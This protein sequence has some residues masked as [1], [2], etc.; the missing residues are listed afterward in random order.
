MSYRTKLLLLF[1]VTV[2]VT[3]TIVAWTASITMR[4]AFERVNNE[5]TAALVT[6]FQR[7][8]TRRGVEVTSQVEGIAHAK[9]TLRIA[10]EVARPNPDYAALVNEAGS[11]A[12][13]YQLEFLELL[14]DD[15]A[16]VSSA[17][18]PARFGYKESWITTTTGWLTQGAFLRQEDLPN[19]SALALM[20]V[21][22]VIVGEKR[23]YV[24]GGKK[25]GSEFLASLTLPEGMRALLYR[26][27]S[28][29]NAQGTLTDGAGTAISEERLLPLIT[30]VRQRPAEQAQNIAWTK[31]AASAEAFHALPLLGPHQEVLGMFLVG[32]SLAEEVLLARR[33]RSLAL[34]A[35]GM[36]IL[37]GMI[38]STWA[39]A[40]VTKP[41]EQLAGAAN[42]VSAG[43]WNTHV[44]VASRD[45]VGRLADAFNRMTEQLTEQRE[46][47]VQA[48]RVAAW[49]E[50]ARRLAHEL[51]N[52]LF[53][54]QITVENLLRAREMSEDQ[55]EEVFRESTGTLLAELAKLRAIISRFSDFAKMPAPQLQPVNLNE[56][57][58]A[59]IRVFEAQFTAPGKPAITKQLDL[60]KRL[61][62]IQADPELLQRAVQNLI[63]N[64]I[65][66]MPS[67]GTLR[68][69]TASLPSGVQ[70][71]VSDTG[72]G[73]TREECERLF[74]PYYTTKQH[75]TGLGLAIVQSVVSDHQGKISVESEP[76]KGTTFR[77]ILPFRATSAEPGN[78]V[79]EPASEP[80]EKVVRL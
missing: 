31:D 67:G 47:L 20:A 75:G 33:I 36:G 79:Q 38:L 46:R 44:P 1:A 27:S 35:G 42:D 16:I 40:H 53:P 32:S 73:L 37:L 8:F 39:A 29:E 43:L 14:A 56:L 59:A 66:A 54:L 13:A 34:I 65:D 15:G 9:D 25:L 68:L 4:R 64:A 2:G 26:N 71:D 19:G 52:P 63:L 78:Q 10:M 3:V 72:T 28:T 22:A 30:A 55:F 60:A 45:E 41:L 23:M 51:K 61:D 12:S 57:V 70:L 77:I 48:E 21:R 76:E 74:T 62:D 50:L 58:T 80:V 49:R 7:E 69:R 6:Q 18:W 11:L 17:Q 5:R 24:V